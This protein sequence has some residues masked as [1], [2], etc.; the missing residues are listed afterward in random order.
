MRKLRVG[1]LGVIASSLLLPLSAVA[2]PIEV[3]YPV[4]STEAVPL[5]SL[6]PPVAQPYFT[7]LDG[8]VST[9]QPTALPGI[10]PVPTVGARSAALPGDCA[11]VR[12]LIAEK[13]VPANA[14]CGGSWTRRLSVRVVPLSPLTAELCRPTETVGLPIA[15]STPA[16]TRGRP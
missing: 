9:P 8:T 10:E 16:T 4:P 15:A 14:L 12:Q 1:L 5:A 11:Q 2:D 3:V 6:T 13:K 7:D